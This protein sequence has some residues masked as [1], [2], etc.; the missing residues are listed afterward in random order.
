MSVHYV[1]QDIIREEERRGSQSKHRITKPVSSES[2]F[3]LRATWNYT[4]Q[5]R[6]ISVAQASVVY[7]KLVQ[8]WAQRS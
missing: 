8:K 2:N 5:I 6:R 4:L 7:E 3:K 1:A